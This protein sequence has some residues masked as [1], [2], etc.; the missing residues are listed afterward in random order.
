MQDFEKLG[1][2]YLGRTYDPEQRKPQDDLLLYDSRD[3][4][5]HAVCVGMTGSGKTGLCVALI[6]EAA[7]DG[8]PAILID[9]KG[10]L[11][12]L[13]LGFPDLRAEDFLPWVNSDEARTQGLSDEQFA[14]QQAAAW[15][16]GLKDWGQDGARIRRMQAAADFT[17]YTP[18]S[19]AG[20]PVSILSSFAPPSQDVLDEPELRRERVQAAAAGIL[21]LT[22]IDV[23]ENS[24]E[25]T[26]LATIFDKAWS[27]GKSLDLEGLIGAVQRP[28]F[29]RMGALDL[30]AFYPE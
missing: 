16:Q 9:P 21:V 5:T 11:S 15:T 28:P 26:I 20:V 8:V 25:Q 19:S 1:A 24:R 12:N 27:E 7:I 18:R 14:A 3:L 22:G 6:E 13:L 29:T 2:F 10:D 30:N 17:V 4:V 23:E